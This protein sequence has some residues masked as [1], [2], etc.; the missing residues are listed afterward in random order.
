[1]ALANAADDESKKLHSDSDDLTSDGHCD[2]DDAVGKNSTSDEVEDNEDAMHALADSNL[3]ADPTDEP[4]LTSHPRNK[5]VLYLFFDYLL[6]LLTKARIRHDLLRKPLLKTNSKRC[7]SPSPAPV[8]RMYLG[9]LDYDVTDTPVPKAPKRKRAN[10]SHNVL[11][12]ILD[13]IGYMSQ[14]MCL[15]QCHRPT[16][17][18]DRASSHTI[19]SL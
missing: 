3:E 16:T 11:D 13:K 5:K 4:W 19:N 7:R 12:G 2:A 18:K 17:R 8:G 9:N 1:V 6:T 10:P 14:Q 15:A